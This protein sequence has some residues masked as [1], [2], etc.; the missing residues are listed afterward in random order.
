MIWIC[1]F[2][3]QLKPPMKNWRKL[4][5]SMFYC[6]RIEAD[7]LLEIQFLIMLL[8]DHIE[9]ISSNR[10][11]VARVMLTHLKV[12]STVSYLRPLALK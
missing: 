12:T 11:N 2:A 3:S 7:L 4:V 5:R 1:V 10:H 6:Q 9:Y 8:I